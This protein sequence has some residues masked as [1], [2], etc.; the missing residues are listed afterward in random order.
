M[1]L[2][3]SVSVIGAARLGEANGARLARAVPDSRADVKFRRCMKV[4]R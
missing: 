1:P 3:A 2:A 4:L